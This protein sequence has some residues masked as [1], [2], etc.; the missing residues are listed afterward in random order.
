MSE[1]G[2]NGA[3]WA[4]FVAKL[5]AAATFE[6]AAA[7]TLAPMIELSAAALAEGRFGA[8][9]KVVRGM[10]HLRPGDG[11]RRLAVLEA[12]GRAVTGVE[13]AGETGLPSATAW[14]WVAEHKVAVSVDVNLGR[15]QVERANPPQ[16]ISDRRFGE[17]EFGSQESRLRLLQRAAT[18]LYVLP[19]RGP[20]DAVDG[21]ISL[22]ADCRAAIGLPFVWGRGAEALQLFADLAAP[23]LAGLPLAPA[24]PPAV[25]PFLPVVGE[26]LGGLV[27][28]LRVFAQQEEPI[29]ISGP[30][31]TGKSRLAR[32]CHEQSAAKGRPFEIIDLSAVPEELQMAELFGWKKGAFTGAVKDNPGFVA[33]ARGGTLFI[34]EV[35]NLSARAQAGLLRV[36]EERT[37][38]VLGDEGGERPAEVRFIIGTNANL[39]EAVRDRR[40][41]QDLYYRINV[42]PVRL[43]PLAER[44]DEIALWAQY[45]LERRHATRFPNGRA[46]V[47]KGAR[48]LLTRQP[49][50][51]NLRQLDNI[52]RRAYAIASLAQGGVATQE[53]RVEE[54]HV[55]RA[56]AYEGPPGEV[57]SSAVDALLAAA[58]ALVAA[59]EQ[60]AAAGGSLDLDWADAFKGF[61]L[62]VAAEKLGGD[63]DEAF[64]LLGREK[65]VA[66]RN[67]HKVWKR[68]LE[69]AEQLCAALG[70]KTPFPFARL[71][72]DSDDPPSK[73]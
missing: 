4:E 19:L 8:D 1:A 29:L 49:W 16:T 12:G 7:A 48:E 55:R 68:E 46:H 56:L 5:R 36:L 67:H 34:D 3:T 73:G 59:A 30:T 51:G 24:R 62:G 44:P 2:I 33:R 63:R 65:L 41:R 52:V 38:H 47:A 45:M 64:R 43:P 13:A 53:L 40:F 66:S 9:A 26:S 54:A 37:Y 27:E 20:R 22:E 18:H 11:Y 25:D 31:G 17:G 69:R 6:E 28:L 21:M 14:R 15:V 50:P 70:R 61:V 39:E 58:S 72:A 23:Y 57:T 60:R 71:L 35:D 32:W 10:I 42:L